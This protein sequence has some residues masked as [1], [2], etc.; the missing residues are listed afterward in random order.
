LKRQRRGFLETPT[1]RFS[2]NANGVSH[3][4]PR[5]GTTLGI[6]TKREINA[7]SVGL[8]DDN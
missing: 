3:F 6:K 4:Q 1:A 8:K 5:V 2:R 7:E